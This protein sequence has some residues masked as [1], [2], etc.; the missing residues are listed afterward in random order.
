MSDHA[1]TRPRPTR[2][3]L[4]VCAGNI[5]RSP[6][7]EAVIR[8][9][10]A[11]RSAVELEVRSRG[12]QDWNVGR[13]AHPAMTRIAAERGY[14]LSAHIAAQVTAEDLEWADDVLVM[15]EENYQQLAARFPA[16]FLGHV[17]LLD[18]D[19]IP[20]PWL[21]DQDHAYTSSLDRIELAVRAYLT[22]LEANAQHR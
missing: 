20:D 10:A 22:S 18:P 15:D 7:A 4:V 14:D 13:H 11:G 17:R 6:T 5:C 12:T 19:G 9:L 8:L 3:V 2:R 1:T 16:D 21:V